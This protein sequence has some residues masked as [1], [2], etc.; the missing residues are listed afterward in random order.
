[1]G[2]DGICQAVGK[3]QQVVNTV[4]AGDAF[5]AAFV[6]HLLDGAPMQICA[7][8]ANAIG[9]FVTTQDGGMPPLPAHFRVF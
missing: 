7:E 9:G 8:Q 4:G 1:L 3:R 5:T 6:M 2:E